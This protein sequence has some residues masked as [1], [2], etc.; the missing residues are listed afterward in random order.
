MKM[1]NEECRMQNEKTFRSTTDRHDFYSSFCI[2]HFAFRIIA[3]G[4]VFLISISPSKTEASNSKVGTSG[5][6][7]L[8]IGAGARPT[9]MGDAFVGIAD[10]VNAIDYKTRGVVVC[11]R[12]TRLAH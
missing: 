11:P 10:D 4:V 9:A 1:K 2:L 7:F 6:L 8:K 5:A 12:M 3:L